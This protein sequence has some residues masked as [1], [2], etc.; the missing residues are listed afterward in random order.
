MAKPLVQHAEPR[1]ADS[2]QPAKM[3]KPLVQHAG[4]RLVDSTQPAK[5]AKPR[6]Y[7]AA[8]T[9]ATGVATTPARSHKKLKVP[10]VPVI[11]PE[12][13]RRQAE[14]EGLLLIAANN[15]SGYR[16]VHI[17]LTAV[18]RRWTHPYYVYSHINGKQ[19]T[20]GSFAC[21]EQAALCYARHLGRDKC[22]RVQHEVDTARA[23]PLSL[24]EVHAKAR[25]EGLE[26]QRYPE[27]RNRGLTGYRGVT[28]DARAKSGRTFEANFTIPGGQGMQEYL[29]RF[30]SA[31]EAALAHAR[32]A[33]RYAESWLASGFALPRPKV[34]NQGPRHAPAGAN[35]RSRHGVPA[36]QKLLLP[37]ED[38]EGG[39]G[40]EG[41]E[42]GEGGEGGEGAEEDDD[43]E[44]EEAKED[45]LVL[46]GHA[47]CEGEEPAGG[48]EGMEAEAD[49]CDEGDEGDDDGN[50]GSLDVASTSSPSPVAAAA[51]VARA[52]GA[53][54]SN[55]TAG[56]AASVCSIC[57]EAV[58][59]SGGDPS[60]S[61][62]QAVCCEA[63]FHYQCLCKWLQQ[64]A[65]VNSCPHC[66]R[67]PKSMSSRRLLKR[68]DE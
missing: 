39:E 40:G 14:A 56:E 65:F 62:G 4:P 5:I 66:R 54:A 42:G 64:D 49:D 24:A 36:Q 11:S 13:A 45:V 8:T 2:K 59:S 7:T 37:E 52:V 33:R 12:E 47:V 60:M 68:C 46:E 34:R 25:E 16:G 27:N 22:L 10:R 17:K 19:V 38:E 28:L 20:L 63:K 48:W 43:V 58:S 1:L 26:L 18:R 31:E 32:H 44:G 57:L 50:E 6:A 55:G 9:P 21:K 67:R 41:R 23:Q 61:W 3:A 51:A 29:G 35:P 15:S 53:D 30:W